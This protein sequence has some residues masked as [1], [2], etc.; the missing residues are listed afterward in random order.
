MYFEKLGGGRVGRG[1]EGGFGERTEAL[2]EGSAEDVGDIGAE[3]L[4]DLLA[5]EQEFGFEFSM[6]RDGIIRYRAVLMEPRCWA[7]TFSA[8][9]IIS[10]AVG[11]LF[12]I[13][14]WSIVGEA[15]VI[16]L[17]TW[18]FSATKASDLALR[19]RLY[20]R[21]TYALKSSRSRWARALLRRMFWKLATMSPCNP[22]KQTKACWISRYLA[23]TISSKLLSAHSKYSLSYSVGTCRTCED[24][25]ASLKKS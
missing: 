23:L 6:Q 5:I 1:F 10:M 19:F 7:M 20:S 2:L 12:V 9:S 13:R 18:H 21:T 3:F 4:L 17:S 16:I 22:S 11:I 8:F 24:S 14:S 15:S 25:W